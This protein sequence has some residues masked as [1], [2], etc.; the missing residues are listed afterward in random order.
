[1]TVR[2]GDSPLPMSFGPDMTFKKMQAAA[3]ANGE[4][5]KFPVFVA[6]LMSL[7]AA[8]PSRMFGRE[9]KE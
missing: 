8:S 9:E 7:S 6:A 1:V 4:K 3:R 2:P 5:E